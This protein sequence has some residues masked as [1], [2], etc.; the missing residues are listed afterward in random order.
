MKSLCRLLSVL[1]L[2]VLLLCY[3]PLTLPQLLGYD[4]S[5]VISASMEPAIKT[6]GLVYY[7]SVDPA[8]LKE[9]DI[10]VFRTSYGADMSDVT[11]RVLTNDYSARQVTTKGDA[12]PNPDFS[13]IPYE[14]VRGR[15]VKVISF[16]GKLA[17]FLTSDSGKLSMAGLLL[18]AILFRIAANVPS[19][20]RRSYGTK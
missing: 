1:L 19:P 17:Q 3:L 2:L 20:R 5:A 9:G 13:P 4:C 11:H 8:V 12:N 10:I 7:R 18:P 6:G 16:G 14:L 15:V